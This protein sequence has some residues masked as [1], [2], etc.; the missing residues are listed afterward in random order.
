VEI[1]EMQS[2]LHWLDLE[3]EPDVLNDQVELTEEKS[4]GRMRKICFDIVMWLVFEHTLF[5]KVYSNFFQ[6]NYSLLY[7][8]VMLMLKKIYSLRILKKTANLTN[9]IKISYA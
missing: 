7:L 1:D 3:K 6:L 8:I 2:V 4:D 9:F 5:D